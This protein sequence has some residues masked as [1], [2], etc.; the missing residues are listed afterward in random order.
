MIARTI[1]F[2][3]DTC[4][5]TNSVPRPEVPGADVATPSGWILVRMDTM[6]DPHVRIETSTR[7]LELVQGE[8]CGI[9]CFNR[10]LFEG[11]GSR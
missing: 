11:E 1:T 8:W 6:V 10:T 9:S 4:R 7:R 3:C 5:R 2:T